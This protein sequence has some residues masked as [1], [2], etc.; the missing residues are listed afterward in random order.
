MLVE[1]QSRNKLTT[2]NFN[3]NTTEKLQ[4][5]NWKKGSKIGFMNHLL[6]L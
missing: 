3:P 4:K 5:R 1:A 6:N 2:I